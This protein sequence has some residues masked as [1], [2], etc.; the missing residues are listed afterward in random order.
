MQL[1]IKE[2]HQNLENAKFELN[3]I[4]KNYILSKNDKL[5]NPN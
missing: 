4:I 5:K 1:N 2:L 3:E